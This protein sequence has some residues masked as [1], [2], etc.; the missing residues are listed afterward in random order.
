M[1]KHFHKKILLLSLLSIC[2]YGFSQ[3]PDYHVQLLNE[4]NGIQTAYINGLTKDKNGFLW[5]LSNRMVQR[6]DGQTAKRIEVEGEELFDIIADSSNRVWV[7]SNTSIKRFIN[8]NK[9]FVPVTILRQANARF[10]KLQV[11]TDKQVWAMSNIG[12]FHFND[13]I[14]AFEPYSIKN[15]EGETYDRR[16]LYAYGNHLFFTNGPM[17]FSFDT[18]RKNLREIDFKNLRNIIGLSDDIY[19]LTNW[20]LQT[21]EINLRTDSMREIQMD[22]FKPA[23]S[24]P[25][26]LIKNVFPVSNEHFF[27]STNQGCYC[28]YPS[29]GNFIKCSLFHDGLRLHEDE[30]TFPSYLDASGI[31][32][33]VL[34]EG[35]VFFNPSV[36]T[37]G[38]LRSSTLN[39]ANLWNNDIRA[40][41]EDDQQNLWLATLNGFTRLNIP[42]GESKSFRPLSSYA[43]YNFPSVRGLVFDGKRLIVGPT[44]GGIIFFD[45][46]SEKFSRPE[47]SGSNADSVMKVMKTDF[48]S[49]IYPCRN[50][51]FL[52]HAKAGTYLIRENKLASVR[53]GKGNLNVQAV[54]EDS[55]GNYWLACF[56]GIA[57][58][59]SAFRITYFDS[60]FSTYASAIVIGNDST[61]IA[62]G[63]GL[64]RID[65]AGGNFKKQ[66]ILPELQNQRINILYK[67]KS[68]RIW[69]GADNGLYRYTLP[70][71]KLEW[72]D[73]TDN[74]QNKRFNPGSLLLSKSGYLFL[75]GFNGINYFIPEK[76]HPRNETLNVLVSSVRI[77]HE[78]SVYQADDFPLKLNRS[79][80]TLQF[81]FTTPY[82]NNPGKLQYRYKLSGSDNSWIDN[83]RN[84]IARF[85]SLSPGDY[86]FVAAAS[87]DGLHWHET[88]FPVQFSIKPAFWETA[89]FAV[90]C[91]CLAVLIGFLILR[92]IKQRQLRDEMKKMINYFTI[93]GY[94]H[95]TIE[96]IIW[97]IAR[98]CVSRLSFEDC[99]IY[100]VDKERKVLVQTAAY[101]NKNPSGTEIYNLIEIPIGKGIVGTVANTGK[102][103]II[104]DTSKDSRYVIDDLHRLSEITVPILHGD[105][106]IGVIDS[107]HSKKGF[108][109][110]SHLQVLQSVASICAVKIARV[111]ALQAAMDKE[112]KMKE[113]SRLMN[114][115]KLA[116][117]QSQMNPHFIFNAMNSI[118]HFT[119]RHDIEN[120]N[121]YISRFSRLL[122]MV[123]HQSEKNTI[124]L[125]DEIEMLKLYLDIESVRMNDQLSFSVEVDEEL[126]TDAI[127]IPGMMVQPLVE[128]ALVHG[129]SNKEGMKRISIKFYLRDDSFLSCEISDNG[130]GR[131]KAA[132]RKLQNQ[133]LLKHDSK[134]MSLIEKRLA[135][136]ENKTVKHLFVSDQ[137][138]SEGQP[139]GTTVIIDIPVL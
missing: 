105:E 6:Y 26:I 117:L 68:G 131:S 52:V 125:S 37:I 13:A 85:S 29:T 54:T 102:A 138:D 101:G 116:A 11:T 4:N 78:D 17:V 118:Q 64:Y 22:R 12:I 36:H 93:S 34:E 65:L 82:F 122:R 58:T 76:I 60:S 69:I 39:K 106:V 112:S 25:F 91:I 33:M 132:E 135:L 127:K 55:K 32:W 114:E 97:D 137:F 74:L 24:S 5:V 18:K 83:G 103:E 53:I 8:D 2:E 109:K 41:T 130:I 77:N 7:S 111:M 123:L 79:Q 100:L 31:F 71:G 47:I 95:S 66:L 30:T 110:K 43:G 3:L 48:I 72:F 10:Y 16:M 35:I 21:F 87:L 115:T 38:W 14:N 45:P 120:A 133:K 61:I 108:F 88:A 19:W 124:S 23:L 90:L 92:L 28:Y 98:N 126:E 75:G 1:K 20:N 134:G 44:H 119:L 113:L 107:E 73:V 129:L 46:A 67:D 27:V 84:N 89:W 56:K 99:V 62:G 59:D 42:T 51:S 121:K 86:S 9:G 94:E 81:Q 49:G 104:N 80:N 70:T 63:V 139:S 15:L 50:G 57:R 40:M 136:F 128:N 96:E